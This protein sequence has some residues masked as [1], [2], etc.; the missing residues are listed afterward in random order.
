MLERNKA[1]PILDEQ[2]GVERSSEAES[3]GERF[4]VCFEGDGRV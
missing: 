4:E 3:G 1:G 2:I